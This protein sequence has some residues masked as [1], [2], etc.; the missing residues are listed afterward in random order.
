ML[1]VCSL[2]GHHDTESGREALQAPADQPVLKV[3][4]R[5]CKTEACILML[6]AGGMSA[7]MQAGERANSGGA[8]REAVHP[9]PDRQPD[10]G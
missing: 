7:Q 8:A 10:P 4:V 3:Q 9:G 1:S 2:G 5:V 6:M